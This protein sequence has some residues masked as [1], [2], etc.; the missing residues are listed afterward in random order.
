MEGVERGAEWFFG[1]ALSDVVDAPGLPFM[2][3]AIHVLICR[4]LPL[5]IL[6]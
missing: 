1:E 3:F 6:P 4:L 2:T 5:D